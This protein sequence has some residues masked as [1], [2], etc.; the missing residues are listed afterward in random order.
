M[1]VQTPK[2]RYNNYSLGFDIS[3]ESVGGSD[4]GNIL[5]FLGVALRVWDQSRLGSYFCLPWLGW[6]GDVGLFGERS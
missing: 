3:L 5:G 4:C 6:L 1:V 2:V